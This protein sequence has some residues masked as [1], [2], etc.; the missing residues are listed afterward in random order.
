[1]FP[2]AVEMTNLFLPSPHTPMKKTHFRLWK[3][4]SLQEKQQ[5][6]EFRFKNI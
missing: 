3:Y 4:S 2:G 6:T 5:E 1:M